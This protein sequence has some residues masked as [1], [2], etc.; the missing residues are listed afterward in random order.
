MYSTTPV[1]HKI[2]EMGLRSKDGKKLA[3][4]NIVS[5][6]KDPFYYGMAKSKYG[7]YEHH[8]PRLI[9]KALFD[10][11][12]EVFVA[13]SRKQSKSTL[14]E[15]MFQGLLPCGTC[16]CLYS[17]ET[18]KGNN[19]YSCTNAKG[20]CKRV[21]VNEKDLLK[22]IYEVLARFESIPLDVQQRLVEE[23]RKLNET[24]ARFY[25]KE[26]SRVNAE[27]QR[28]QEK[29][30]KLLDLLIEE[31]ITKDDYDKKLEELKD[32][33]YRLSIELEEHTKAD[34]QYHIHVATVINLCRRIK[35]IFEGSEVSEKRAILNFILQNP[36][37]SAKKLTFTLRKPLD[38]VLELASLSSFA[39]R[40]GLE[41]GT[42]A[43]HVS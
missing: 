8:Y 24:E 30:K 11:C 40:P 42:I 23:L 28:V 2:T 15:Y 27:H 1:W 14:N 38:V 7:T 32:Q 20:I 25:E 10:Q 17:P 29:I 18:H 13:R 22:P 39:P 35:E 26:F 16:G 33:Q 5:I 36:T 9:T 6:L 21:Y 31:S 37:V 19:Y 34:H 4:S 43:L 41:P 3:R 12:Q